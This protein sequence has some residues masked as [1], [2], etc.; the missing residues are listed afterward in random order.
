MGNA[1][2]PTASSPSRKINH[3]SASRIA[4]AIIA[5]DGGERYSARA[6]ARGGPGHRAA[7]NR[8]GERAKRYDA[9]EECELSDEDEGFFDRSVEIAWGDQSL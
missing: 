5:A 9:P 4:C 1:A 3:A 7:P 2:E 8:S 6:Q